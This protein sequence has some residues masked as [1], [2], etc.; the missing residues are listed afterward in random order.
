MLTGG[1]RAAKVQYHS[2]EDEVQSPWDQETLAPAARGHGLVGHVISSST[3]AVRTA[4]GNGGGRATQQTG[5]LPQTGE[6]L[7]RPQSLGPPTS[8]PHRLPARLPR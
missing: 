1:C 3:G 5:G 4:A 7:R 2:I 6:P 8:R